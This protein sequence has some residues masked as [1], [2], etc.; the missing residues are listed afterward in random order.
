MGS[1]FARK[2][3]NKQQRESID[4]QTTPYI[5]SSSSSG[6]STAGLSGSSGAA[7]AASSLLSNTSATDN[8]LVTTS[9]LLSHG[10]VY[11]GFHCRTRKELASATT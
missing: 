10:S 1:I 8:T 4:C 3:L 5:Y 11:G 9:F 6:P 2:K 7:A